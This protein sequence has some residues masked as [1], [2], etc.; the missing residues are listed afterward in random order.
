MLE[1]YKLEM[2][3]RWQKDVPQRW[4]HLHGFLFN[5]LKRHFQVNSR[6]CMSQLFTQENT[7]ERQKIICY[8]PVNR[9]TGKR[10]AIIRWRKRCIFIIF[11]KTFELE[12]LYTIFFFRSINNPTMMLRKNN[13]SPRDNYQKSNLSAWLFSLLRY[14]SYNTLARPKMFIKTLKNKTRR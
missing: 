4:V 12:K 8:S 10:I 5:S 11:S 6:C 13:F 9:S 7:I 1:K 14:T 2:S 3:I